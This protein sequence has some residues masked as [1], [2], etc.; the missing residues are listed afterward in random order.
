MN[1]AKYIKNS[2]PAALLAVCLM[3]MLMTGC[4]DKDYD[5]S[6]VVPDVQS[7]AQLISSDAN[8]SLL[9]QALSRA[10]L[11]ATFEGPGP[12]TLFAPTN[13]AFEAVGLNA[14]TI[15]AIDPALLANVL[16]YHVLNAAVKSQDIQTGIN[17]ATPT[18]NG[19]AFVSNF[20]YGTTTDGNNASYGVSVNGS[21]V[22]RA[23]IMATN[24]VIHAVDAVIFPA[25]MN[26]VATLQ[27]NPRYSLLVAAV[28]R[29]GLVDA[30]SGAGPF[31]VFAPTNE[32]F[33]E[34]GIT[35]N[36]IATMPVADLANILR[37]HVINGRVFSTNF[38]PSFIVESPDFAGALPTNITVLP[39]LLGLES[40]N[41]LELNFTA[42]DVKLTGNNERLKDNPVQANVT[43]QDFATRANVSATNGVIHAIDKVLLPA[44]DNIVATLQAKPNFSL[45]VRAVQQAN[46]VTAL[47]GAGPFTLFAPTDEA[48]IDYLGIPRKEKFISNEDNQEKERDRTKEA[49][50]TDAIN[51]INAANPGDLASVLTYHVVANRLYSNNLAAGPLATLSNGQLAVTL[52]DG[53]KIK[54]AGNSE[55]ASV[56]KINLGTTNGIIHII[57]RVLQRN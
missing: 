2:L 39:T 30:L 26:I 50:M 15:A 43:S 13:A 1:I 11:A 47:S 10:N 3:A 18:L 37:Y 57:D 14:T 40:N 52:N 8:Y 51:A 6:D 12:F 38:A 36:A 19:T 56:T 28:V 49:I 27:A 24:G 32:A 17:R 34:A 53:V 35:Q 22:I 4:N 45:L 33:A 54:G 20:N 41:I 46:L 9:Q 21:R 31:T 5:D 7:I 44:T 23:D 42:N 48:F 16:R 25:I 55:A 29:A